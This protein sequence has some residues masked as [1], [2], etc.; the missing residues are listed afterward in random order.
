[1]P[2]STPRVRLQWS[3]CTLNIRN[4][5]N[6]PG[7]SHAQ[8]TLGS[9]G[10]GWQEGKHSGKVDDVSKGAAVRVHGSQERQTCPETGSC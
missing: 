2:G 5:E 3:G 7:D 8:P 10:L 4:L 6:I 1:M 9:T